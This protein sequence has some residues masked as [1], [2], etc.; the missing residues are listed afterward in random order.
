MLLFRRDGP[1]ITQLFEGNSFA[2]AAKSRI[3]INFKQDV[4]DYVYTFM[5]PEEYTLTKS[6]AASCS[7]SERDSHSSK[8][9]EEELNDR[10]DEDECR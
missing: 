3:T 8:S 9:G 4:R 10:E 5:Y 7:I 2:N 6:I 1:Y